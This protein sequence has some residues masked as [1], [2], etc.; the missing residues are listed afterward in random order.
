MEA[1]DNKYMTG[2]EL[3]A[4]LLAPGDQASEEDYPIGEAIQRGLMALDLCE[5]WPDAVE[6]VCDGCN[7]V[8][9]LLGRVVADWHMHCGET[10]CQSCLAAEN[11]GDEELTKADGYAWNLE[12]PTYEPGCHHMSGC[13]HREG[14]CWYDSIPAKIRKVNAWIAAY[15]S[16]EVDAKPCSF[17][18]L[19]EELCED[20]LLRRDE[21]ELR[22][23]V[24]GG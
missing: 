20:E 19:H 15:T 23:L 10:L 9:T 14:Y 3:M 11:D 16:D 18:L 6:I 13:R 12:N 17:D 24:R 7:A 8:L 5:V 22:H 4:W 2:P 1:N 21:A